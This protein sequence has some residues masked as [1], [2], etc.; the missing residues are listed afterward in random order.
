MNGFVDDPFISA[1]F[2]QPVLVWSLAISAA[3]FVIAIGLGAYFKLRNRANFH[4]SKR[5]LLEDSQAD[6]DYKE[7]Q[8]SSNDLTGT[9]ESPV[10]LSRMEL[11][12]E[13]FETDEELLSA[14]KAGGIK[15]ESAVSMS[16][17]DLPAGVVEV[18]N[19]DAPKED[20]TE[21]GG[22]DSSKSDLANIFEEEIIVDPHLQ[23]MRDN[24]PNINIFKL[25]EDT[26][27]V[28]SQLLERETA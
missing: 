19:D 24:L 9:N 15:M 28:I 12:S 23:A 4:Q 5:D 11:N 20:N 26:Q 2:D 16:E 1:L 3:I 17:S 27:L 21:S 7:A 22:S 13:Q 14:E 10:N 8:S 18:T 6:D 25:K